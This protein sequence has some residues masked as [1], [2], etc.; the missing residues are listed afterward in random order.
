MQK[1]NI[2][3]AAA[4][5][6]AGIIT[7]GT[8]IPAAAVPAMADSAAETQQ[9]EKADQTG[10]TEGSDGV[11][12]AD[13]G[14]SAL[15]V[16]LQTAGSSQVTLFK[17]ADKKAW[18]TEKTNFYT[19]PSLASESSDAERFTEVKVTGESDNLTRIEYSGKTYYVSTGSL[20]ESE[21]QVKAMKSAEE[22]NQ[23]AIQKTAEKTLN[24]DAGS[25]K[26]KAY[27]AFQK[28]EAQKAAEA[29]KKQAEEKAEKERKEAEEKAARENAEND[30][31]DSENS[32]SSQRTQS[33]K[34]DASDTGESQATGNDTRDGIISLA[35]TKLGNPYVFGAEG[36]YSFDCSGFT[37][38]LYRRYGMSIP[39]SA[40]EQFYS[41]ERTT[42]P[43]PGDLVF[44]RNTYKA[45]ISHVGVYIGGGMMIHAANSRKGIITS[46]VNSSYYS[47]HF[48]GFCRM[49]S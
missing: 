14:T 25:E 16:S 43:Q 10:N 18:L 42:D 5:V 28:E 32:A 35:R 26:S 23:Q 7:A 12:T 41:M 13:Q 38:W 6:A 36:P 22:E 9:N 21:A 48:A 2:R 46:A 37:Q 20:T 40:A 31:S 30:N 19:E 17:S 29:A 4:K 33:Y 27:S 47:R 15:S 8:A 24:A 11:Q 3:R 34:S 39:R 45:G 49:G 1:K 44:F